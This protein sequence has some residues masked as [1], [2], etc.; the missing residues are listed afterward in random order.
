MAIRDNAKICILGKSGTGKTSLS[1]RLVKKD[2][3]VH[4]E[5]QEPTI[6]ASFFSIKY[7]DNSGKSTNVLQKCICCINSL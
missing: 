1:N 6:G 7:E 2:E 3:Y 5:Y 4:Y